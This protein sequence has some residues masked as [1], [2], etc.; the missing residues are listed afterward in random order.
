[1]KNPGICFARAITCSR[2]IIEVNQETGQIFSLSNSHGELL[3]VLQLFVQSKFIS[4]PCSVADFDM[5][6]DSMEFSDQEMSDQEMSNLFK[7]GIKGTYASWLSIGDKLGLWDKTR[8]FNFFP[9]EDY[10]RKPNPN[11]SGVTCDY[12]ENARNYPVTDI[13]SIDLDVFDTDPS[14]QAITLSQI[15]ERIKTAKAVMLFISSSH[16]R[17][18]DKQTIV[19]LIRQIHDAFLAE[20]KS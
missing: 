1:M 15:L 3:P 11:Y 13:L 14:V 2:P 9:H 18:T 16:I 10:G 19:E 5:H 17:N 7:L 4:V 20:K 6:T 12:A 8:A